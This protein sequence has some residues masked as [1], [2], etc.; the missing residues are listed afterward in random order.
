L[1]KTDALDA[2]ILARYGECLHPSPTIL[3]DKTFRKMR[4]LLVVRS[5][6]VEDYRAWQCR[7]R[8]I[9]P[10]AITPVLWTARTVIYLV[11]S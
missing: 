10:S 5:A 6:L 8:Q 2:Q 9:D 3:A 11:V 7:A 1:E 4:D